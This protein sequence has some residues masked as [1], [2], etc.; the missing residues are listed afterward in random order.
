MSDPVAD[1]AD[2][3]DMAETAEPSAQATA[4]RNQGSNTEDSESEEEESSPDE[5]DY[6]TCATKS[7]DES[8]LEIDITP[9]NARTGEVAALLAPSV[10]RSDNSVVGVNLLGRGTCSVL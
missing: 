3:A 4:S 6:E 9:T 8:D 2:V 5:E 10:R 7:Q 1:V